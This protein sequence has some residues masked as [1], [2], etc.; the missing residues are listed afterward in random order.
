MEEWKMSEGTPV[1]SEPTI[2]DF[3]GP[4]LRDRGNTLAEQELHVFQRTDLTQVQKNELRDTFGPFGTGYDALILRNDQ[5]R[6]A[7]M[8]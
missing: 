5:T 3:N 1:T 6:A 8:G 4:G 7:V 2:A